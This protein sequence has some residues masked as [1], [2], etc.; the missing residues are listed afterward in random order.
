M[1]RKSGIVLMAI[2][3]LV[4]VRAANADVHTFVLTMDGLQ[5]VTNDGIPGQGDPDGMG[6][7]T[8][9]IDDADNTI[10]WN[11]DVS[12]ITL[13]PTG[14]HIHQAVQGMNGPIVVNF[15][16]MLTGMDLM[17]ADLANVL[18]NPSGFYVNVHNSDFPAGAIRGQIPE[19]A[20]V[21]LLA[22]GGLALLRR[23]R[24]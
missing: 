14:A 17:D 13:P 11:I 9:M 1:L 21:G 4:F 2:G 8:L 22:L 12:N 18:A 3:A 23:K 16:G 24:G 20:T 6:L 5:E 7:A 15:S 19:P 10:D